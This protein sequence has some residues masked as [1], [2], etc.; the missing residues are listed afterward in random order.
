MA[1]GANNR[2]LLAEL[3]GGVEP[4]GTGRALQSPPSMQITLGL[5]CAITHQI[6][7]AAGRLEVGV[8]GRRLHH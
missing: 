7:M 4:S 5:A 1:A 3:N 8:A 6:V 2:R